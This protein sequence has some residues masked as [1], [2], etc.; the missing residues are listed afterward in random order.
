MSEKKFI[1]TEMQ[2]QLALRRAWCSGY[3][4][5]N[6][7]TEGRANYFVQDM[8]TTE[9]EQLKQINEQPHQG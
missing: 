8:A 4:F 1:I 3:S 7:S 2:M 6:Q 5:A 9:L